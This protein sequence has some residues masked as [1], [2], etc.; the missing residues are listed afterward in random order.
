MAN[1]IA[2]ISDEIFRGDLNEAS[3]VNLPLIAYYLRSNLGRLNN[4]LNT[5]YTIENCNGEVEPYINDQEKDIFKELYKIKYY[6]KKAMDNLGA[7]GIQTALVVES[8]G[9][10]VSLTNRNT[11]ASNYIQLKKQAEE[12]LRNL[13]N[14]Y[15]I[16][17]VK[18]MQVVGDDTYEATY[19]YNDS[20]ISRLN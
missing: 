6:D 7:A 9:A 19:Y 3:D 11:I 12:N 5:S 16:T 13:I 4:L 14:S 18:P 20:D 2:S 10:K 1:T 8:D 15:K 17:K